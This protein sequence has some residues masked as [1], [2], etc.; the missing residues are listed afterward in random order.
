M[1]TESIRK[2]KFEDTTIEY[3]LIRK[4]VKNINLRVKPDGSVVVSAGRRV[5]AKYVD[6]FIV[7]K[8]Q[9]ICDALQKVAIRKNNA[10]QEKPVLTAEDCER[11]KQICEEI[12]PLF[13]AYNI[14]YPEIRIKYLKSM[15]GS[16]R[17]TQ[18]IITFNSRLIY[19][20]GKCIEYVVLHEFAHFI[21]PNHSREFYS[22]VEE[23]MPDYRECIQELKKY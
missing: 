12:Y 6:D 17:P 16:C 13:G 14:P 5:S 15:W 21:H 11:L 18:G 19:T 3:V 20:P 10:P 2:V 23:F 8:G 1:K 4:S 22:F 7:R 9:F